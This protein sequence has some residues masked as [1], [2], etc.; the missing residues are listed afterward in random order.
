MVAAGT[1]AAIHQLRGVASLL[2]LFTGTVAAAAISPF[3]VGAH[4]AVLT[5]VGDRI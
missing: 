5:W 3:G 1:N 4:W 2:V